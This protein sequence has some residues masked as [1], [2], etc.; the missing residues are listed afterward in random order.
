[1]SMIEQVNINR[2]F[3]KLTYPT[4]GGLS[5]K[6]GVSLKQTEHESGCKN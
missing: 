5:E 4:Y 6:G 1:M 2:V 3:M